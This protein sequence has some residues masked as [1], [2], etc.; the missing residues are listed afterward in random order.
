[1]SRLRQGYGGQA[2]EGRA[3]VS[4]ALLAAVLVAGF[5]IWCHV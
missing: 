4:T 3:I 2:D 1:M 5:A